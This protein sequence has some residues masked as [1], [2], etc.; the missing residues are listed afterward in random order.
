[1]REWRVPVRIDL[2]YYCS[3]VVEADTADEAEEEA[4]LAGLS[5]CEGH[6]DL[7]DSH[8]DTTWIEGDAEPI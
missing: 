5:Q 4:R 1:M 2:Q 8:V 7:N 6:T 3:V